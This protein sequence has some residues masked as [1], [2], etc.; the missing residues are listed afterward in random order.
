[1]RLVFDNKYDPGRG[2]THDKDILKLAASSAKYINRRSYIIRKKSNILIYT[3]T[4]I[5]I[6]KYRYLLWIS[7]P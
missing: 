7:A 2:R 3:Y 1:M 6:L 4:Y 5:Q